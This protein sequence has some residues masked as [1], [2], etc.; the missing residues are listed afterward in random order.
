MPSSSSIPRL[1]AWGAFLCAIPLVL[2]G[3]VVT[4]IGA[5]MA[6]KGWWDAEGYFMPFFPL[7]LWLRDVATVVEHG[8]RLWGLLVGLFA[9]VAALGAGFARAPR[10]AVRASWIALLAVCFQGWLGGQRVLENSRDLAFMHGGLAQLVFALLAVAAL[11]HRAPGGWAARGLRP[12]PTGLLWLSAALVY[13]QI[14]LGAWYRHGLRGGEY[15]LDLRFH[16]HLGGAALVLGLLVY[17]ARRLRL[18]TLEWQAAGHPAAAAPRRLARRVHLLLGLQ[19][20]LGFGAWLGHRGSAGQ[21]SVNVLET[22]S[23]VGHV[24]VGALL[25]AALVTGALA[26]GWSAVQGT[27]LA[28][29]D[30]GAAPSPAQGR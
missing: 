27:P 30:A 17:L 3:G 4:T 9:L 12:A 16:L 20:V 11:L 8:H 13:A 25:L 14:W 2:I 6:V 18:L 7:D 29:G 28:G 15:E 22:V 21:G 19:L 24:L 10:A 5:G 1:S 23:A 26:A